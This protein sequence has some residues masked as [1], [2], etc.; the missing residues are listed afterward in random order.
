M[1]TATWFDLGI[2]AVVALNTI[3]MAMKYAR[4]SDEYA[5]ALEILN[6]F[7][8]CLYNVEFIFKFIG[9]GRRYFTG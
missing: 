4:M 2:T 5:L 1:V 9:L 7:F 3:I 6:Y 8:T